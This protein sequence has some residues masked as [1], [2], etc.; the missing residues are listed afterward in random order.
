M[1]FQPCFLPASFF[2][3]FAALLLAAGTA[4][5]APPTLQVGTFA[6]PVHVES[7]EKGLLIDL[8]REVAR[9]AD[10]D[11]QIHVVPP[12]RAVSGLQTGTYAM[13]FPALDVMFPAGAPIV[14]SSEAIE[15]KE[16]FVFTRK[17]DKLLRTLADLKGKRVG[18]T[19]GYPYARELSEGNQ[20]FTL[21]GAVSDES[22]IGKLVAGHIDAFVVDEKTGLEE[23]RRLGMT[24]RMQYDRHLPVSRQE[25]YY[26]FGNSPESP[27]LARRFSEAL[28][29]LKRDGRFRSITRGIALDGCAAR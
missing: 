7:A 23:F 8:V 1:P 28:A 5:A 14:R 20:D 27:E 26:A 4:Q 21:E 16:D 19:R 18:I 25:V 3:T 12:R 17:G 13:L 2:R 6:V 9:T 10:I 15:C 22:N 24:D 11:I 29:Q